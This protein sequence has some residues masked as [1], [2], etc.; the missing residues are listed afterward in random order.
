[1][2]MSSRAVPA[3]V[4]PSTPGGTSSVGPRLIAYSWERGHEHAIATGALDVRQDDLPPLCAFAESI[5]RAAVAAAFDPSAHIGDEL[6]SR[7]YQRSEIRLKQLDEAVRNAWGSVR[8]LAS[9]LAQ[10]ESAV[11]LRPERPLI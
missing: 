9:R 5:V 11:P 1:M 7:T 2:C 3:P 10:A 6:R 4:P 8:D